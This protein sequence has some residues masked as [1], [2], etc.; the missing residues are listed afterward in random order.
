M[1]NLLSITLATLFVISLTSL[2]FDKKPHQKDW[3]YLGSRKVNWGVE[4]DVITVGP[5]V[6]G[7]TKLKVK[8]TGGALNMRKMVVTYGNG[9]KDNI[10][11]KFNFGK[12]AESRVI[13]LQ[14]GKRQIKTITFWY[15]S[16]NKNKQ[17]ATIHVAGRRG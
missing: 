16:K 1:K 10:P 6:T 7:L 4:K 14:G 17:K 13:D 12:G 9:Q 5:K 8:V 2:S 11:L 15:D 3:T